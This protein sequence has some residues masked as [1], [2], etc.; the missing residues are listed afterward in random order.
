MHIIL[1]VTL[2]MLGLIAFYDIYNEI[3]EDYKTYK[4]ICIY[5]WQIFTFIIGV[6]LVIISYKCYY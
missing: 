5:P 2:F 3:K 1:N 6:A 4:R